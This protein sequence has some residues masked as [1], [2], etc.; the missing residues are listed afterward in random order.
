MK[1][2]GFIVS[3]ATI[4]NNDEKILDSF[5][6]ETSSIL[7]DHFS[8]YEI[9]LVENG[10]RDNSLTKI[11][12]L[13]NKFRNIRLTGLSKQY[14]DEIAR[15]AALDNS[16]GDYVILMDINY[17]PP[18]LIPDMIDKA[19]SGYDLVIGERNNRKD[20]N[21]FE[22]ISAK[23]FYSLSKSLTGYNINPNYSDYVCISRKMVNSLVQIRDRSRYLKYLNLEVGFK[24]T[25][26]KYD[27]IKRSNNGN[28]K[29]FFNKLGFA[30]E[31][32]VTNSDKLLRW[33]ALFGFFISFI[34]LFY[35]LYIVLVAVFKKDVAAG[36]I[37]SSLVNTTMFFF[38]FLLLSIISVFISS[39]LKETKKGSLYYVSEETNSSVIY[40][41]IDKKNIV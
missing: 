20:D 38:L 19:L 5:I 29:N 7:S 37:S 14:D 21:L 22:R 3:V 4:L 16:I 15:T 8:N 30:L 6:E 25:A 27:R 11:K 18:S 26:I 28:K 33:S 32:I 35:L 31:V 12:E 10:S 36:W 17:D 34:N 39:V 40:K 24:Q 13:Q 2:D 1:K 41:D 9:V 23:M